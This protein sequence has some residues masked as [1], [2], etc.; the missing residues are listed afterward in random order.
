MTAST[1]HCCHWDIRLR[2]DSLQTAQSASHEEA[3]PWGSHPRRQLSVRHSGQEKSV[4]ILRFHLDLPRGK[5]LINNSINTNFWFVSPLGM[6]KKTNLSPVI[7]LRL[8]F[9]AVSYINERMNERTNERMN[10]WMNGWTNKWHHQQSIVA[11]EILGSDT[12]HSKQHRA[13]HMRRH[14]P[15]AP[16][17]LTPSTVCEALGAREKCVHVEIPSGLAKGKIPCQQFNKY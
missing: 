9:L 8:R 6:E 14:R 4:W 7:Q 10:R 12:I 16:T 17:P 1:K 2:H 5:S 3:S 15:E 13:P 11:I